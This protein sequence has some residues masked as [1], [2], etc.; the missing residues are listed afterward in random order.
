MKQREKTK[1]NR[2]ALLKRYAL[3]G[4]GLGIYFGFFFRP[5]R[6]PSLLIVVGLSLSIAVVTS[7]LKLRGE[8]PSAAQLLKDAGITFAKYALI[9]TILEARHLAHD[10]GGRWAVTAMTTVMGALIGLWWGY[11]R[12]AR[13]E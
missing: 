10:F 11:E 6:E 7:M 13:G 4:A 8:R 12:V 1:Q 3:V 5:V 9:L 2:A